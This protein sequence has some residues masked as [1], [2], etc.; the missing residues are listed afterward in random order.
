MRY[1]EPF[2]LFRDLLKANAPA[3]GRLLGLDVGHKYIGLAV[4]DFKKEIASPLSVL[5]RK[6]T[7]IDEMACDFENLI[8][9]LSLKGFIV[10]YPYDRMRVSPDA[11]QVK[12][13]IDDLCKTEKFQGLPYTFWSER[14]T[15][16][17]EELY[18]K[19][20]QLHPV[21]YKTIIDKF[22]AV[23]ILQ[24]YLDHVNKKLKSQPTE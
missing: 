24:G 15:S 4:S 8:S 9:E 18:L 20:L 1:V 2:T 14:F 7:N 5:V 12:V 23:G 10:G 11:I 3:K 13:F 6:K 17:N 19:D 22:A 21:H 16:K